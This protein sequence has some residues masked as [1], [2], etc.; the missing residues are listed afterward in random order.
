MASKF[1]ETDYNARV[2]LARELDEAVDQFAKDKEVWETVRNNKDRTILQL[3]AKLAF[4]CNDEGH[5]FIMHGKQ[6]SPFC[7]CGREKNPLYQPDVI[8][9]LFGRRKVK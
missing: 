5:R 4:Q 7:L 6:E 1:E 9:Q 2:R 8:E 3:R